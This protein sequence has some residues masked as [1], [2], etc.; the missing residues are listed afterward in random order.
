MAARFQRRAD[1][2]DAAVHHVRRPDDVGAGLGL[3]QGHLHQRLDRAVVHDLAVLDEAVMAVDVVGIER[4]VGHH[5][6]FRHRGLDRAGGA[7]GEVVGAPGLGAILGPVGGF[8][9]GK[10]A[11]RGDAENGRLAR[12]FGHLVDGAAHHAGHGRH[13]LLHALALAHEDGPDQVADGEVVL[14]HEGAQGGGLS[15]PAQARGGI[16]GQSWAASGTCRIDLTVS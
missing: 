5:R 11:D 12:G 1:R 15:H 8:G 6:H 10:D 13:R 14:P 7:V 4:H 2:A 16:G 3:G 9:V